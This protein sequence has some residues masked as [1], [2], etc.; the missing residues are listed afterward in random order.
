MVI[1]SVEHCSVTGLPI[2]LDTEVRQMPCRL[3]DRPAP[4][5]IGRHDV[6]ARLRIDVTVESPEL[7]LN[8]ANDDLDL[9]IAVAT[10]AR[11]SPAGRRLCAPACD[12]IGERC[13]SRLTVRLNA[14]VLMS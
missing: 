14:Q 10:V 3:P 4:S 1:V 12:R 7:T 6:N 5:I 11:G 8:A 13:D 9:S 2:C